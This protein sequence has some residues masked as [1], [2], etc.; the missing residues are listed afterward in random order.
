MMESAMSKSEFDKF[1]AAM[2][3]ILKADPKAVKAAMDADKA[4]NA[5]K[6]KAKKRPSA[7]GR[8]SGGKS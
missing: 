8:V 5:K 2:S 6:R 3:T 1:D 7:L 4:A